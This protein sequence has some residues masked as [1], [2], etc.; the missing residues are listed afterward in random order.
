MIWLENHD[1]VLLREVLHIQPW[2]KRH[3]SVK[4]GQLWDEIAV[5]LKAMVK[6]QEIRKKIS[7]KRKAESEK[8]TRRST[9]NTIKFFS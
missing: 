1:I 5:V 8:K 6:A 7:R 9:N 2:S 4:R 3:L